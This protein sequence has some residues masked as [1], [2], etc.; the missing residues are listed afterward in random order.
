M[1]NRIGLVGNL[2]SA[3][4]AKWIVLCCGHPGRM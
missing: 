3:A 2:S 1:G 4:E